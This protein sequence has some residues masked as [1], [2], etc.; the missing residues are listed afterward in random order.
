[1]PFLIGLLKTVLQI[2]VPLAIQ[3]YFE[4][5]KAEREEAKK[6]K[7]EAQQIDQGEN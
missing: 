1:M 2:A 7:Q 4:R 6:K 3:E 5:K